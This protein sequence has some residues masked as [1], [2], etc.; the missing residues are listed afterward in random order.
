MGLRD[1]DVTVRK[2][3]AHEVV[4]RRMREMIL[5]GELAPGQPVT[6]QG[7]VSRLESGTTP[8]REAIRHLIAEGA[9]TFKDNR[10]IVVPRL[11]LSQLEEL[12]FARLQIEPHLARLGTSRMGA[13]DLKT[14]EQTDDRL[15]KAIIRGDI[16][17]Y[18]EEN[19]AFH[20]ALYALSAAP[21][22]ISIANALWLRVGPSLR[23]VC[24]RVG[25]DNLPDKHGEALA[26][27]RAGDGEAVALAIE[28]DIR[29]GHEHIRQSLLSPTI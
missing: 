1:W 25:M 7:L 28:G 26:A 24:G 4:Y 6:I 3:P 17:A 22:L 29:Q 14:L 21:I 9:L 11:T 20:H 23:V 10:R 27:M 13:G 19:H 2:P 8:V 12:S 5:F 16:R 18:L 15:D